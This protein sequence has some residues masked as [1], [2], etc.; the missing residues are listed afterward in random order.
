MSVPSSDLPAIGICAVHE[1]AKWSFWD[2]PAHLVAD[3]YVAAVQTA[4]G[5][6]LVLPPENRAPERLV[7]L[8]DGLLLVGGADVD[9]ASYGAE[10]HPATE[11]TYPERDAFEI[12]MIHAAVERGLPVFGICRGMQILNVAFGGTLVQDL[13]QPD[14]TNIHRRRPGA[15][16]AVNH[17]ELDERSLVARATGERMH[18]APCH[19]HQAV[20][21]LGDGLV[22][23][24][25][26][27]EDGL[28]EAIEAVDGRWLLGVQ[29]HPE[30]EPESAL[31]A[32]F[33]ATAAGEETDAVF[34]EARAR[35]T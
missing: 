7:Q 32:S 24:G 23:S 18:V 9:P 21:A 8:V 19:H 20:D 6:A 29:W 28:P 15:L 17:I 2:Q 22:V 4:G 31:L 35:G 1:R 30:A 33:V 13:T 5:L 10:R 34:E 3:S 11:A 25:R 16:D 14:G 26:A 12:A 27:V